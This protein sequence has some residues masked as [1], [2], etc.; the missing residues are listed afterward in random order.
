MPKKSKNETIKCKYF[1]WK[2]ASR[3][4]R[5]TADGRSG[6]ASNIGR[7]SLATSDKAEALERLHQLDLVMAVRHGLADPMVLNNTDKKTL[8]LEDGR[9][10]YEEY[11]KRPEVAGGASKSTRA[12]YAAVLD[13]FLP[14]AKA[15]GVDSWPLVTKQLL[16]SY[17]TKLRRDGYGDATLYLEGVLVK[18]LMKWLVGEQLIPREC[19]FSLALRKPTGTSTHC[20]APEEIAAIEKHCRCRP[21]LIWLAD[22]VVALSRT[23]LRI[24]ELSSLRWSDVDFE[25]NVIRVRNDARRRGGLDHDLR[26][27][28]NRKDRIVPL[29]AEL[30]AILERLPRGRDGCVFRGPRGGR[31]KPDTVRVILQRDV[32]APLAERFP[33]PVGVRAFPHGTVHG[34]RHAFISQCA[35]QGIPE[36]TV[37]A[38]VGHASSRITRLYFSLSDREGQRQMSRLSFA[39]NAAG[40][41]AGDCSSASTE[42]APQGEGDHS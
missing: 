41:G 17:L 1:R 25:K 24:R 14:F 9:R 11:L 31:L 39:D 4:G 33:A 40:N 30:R 12:R 29:N 23:G 2:L 8:T 10:R 34:F 35:N 22:V 38:W 13:K 18:Q 27:T 42:E 21:A 26:R 28:K 7:H 36:Q 5:W 6:N 20:F 15:A 16:T 37:M 19:L 32:I 3:C